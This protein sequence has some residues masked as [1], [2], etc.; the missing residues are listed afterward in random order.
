MRLARV[1]IGGTE[2]ILDL[3][4]AY[5]TA[6]SGVQP[7][8]GAPQAAGPWNLI[9]QEEFQQADAAALLASGKWHF[10]WFGDGILTGPVNG[11]ETALYDVTTLSVG[12]GVGTFAVRPNSTNKTLS[13]T[14]AK[15]NLGGS[16][17]SDPWQSGATPGFM[18]SYGYAEARFR[19]PAGNE[20]ETLWPGWWLN[21][22]D[23]PS[24]MEIDIMEGDG[25]DAGCGFNIHYGP[26][27]V[28]TLNL[29]NIP[30]GRTRTV[31]GA[32]SGMHTYGAD[33][34]PDGVTFYYDGIAVYNFAGTVPDVDRY[35]MIGN[36]CAG[37]MSAQKDLVV[38]YVRAW[39]QL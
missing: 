21:G 24:C 12:S 37:T 19:Q 13:G 36:S 32:T 1:I 10:G 11:L 34:R 26:A 8:G 35:L 4:S 16:I 22:H 33:I 20:T 6:P 9:F 17:V 30:G 39:E 18:M 2:R 25:T 7:F 3:A 38:E 5:D 15:A 28:E 29:N 27:T 31:V 23:W 14:P